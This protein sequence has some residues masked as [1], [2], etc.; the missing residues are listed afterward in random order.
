MKALTK[1]L[2][3][4]SQK[5]V[6]K[7]VERLGI[8]R[9]VPANWRPIGS[10]RMNRGLLVRKVTDTGNPKKDW[11]R[12][13]VIEWESVHG[14]I[15]QGMELMVKDASRQRTMDNLG[16]FTKASNWERVKAKNM[17]REILELCQLRARIERE[18]ERLSRQQQAE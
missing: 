17:P 9:Q 5:A 3:G 8:K 4:R 14:P 10:E 7:L 1:Q 11:K 6:R 18:V 15:P 12:V 2:P 16:L 13:D